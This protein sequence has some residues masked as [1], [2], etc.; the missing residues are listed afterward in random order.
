MLKTYWTIIARYENNKYKKV[1]EELREEKLL[2]NFKKQY[3][4]EGEK[5]KTPRIE[6]AIKIGKRFIKTGKLQQTKSKCLKL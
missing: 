3:D 1:S 6:E 4:G 5:I 2:S